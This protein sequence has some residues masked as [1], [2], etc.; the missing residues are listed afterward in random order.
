MAKTAGAQFVEDNFTQSQRNQLALLGVLNDEGELNVHPD[1]KPNVT[2]RT[3]AETEVGAD[4]KF[5]VLGHV[6]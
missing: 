4:K 2:L 1:T 5:A 3:V 6:P